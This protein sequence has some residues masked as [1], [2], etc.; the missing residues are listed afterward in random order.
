MRGPPPRKT[1]ACRL[2]VAINLLSSPDDKG[3]RF[4]HG[5]QPWPDPSRPLGVQCNVCASAYSARNGGTAYVPLSHLRRGSPGLDPSLGGY[6]GGPGRAQP[7]MP[8]EARHIEA[9]EG[10]IVMYHAVSPLIF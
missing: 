1:F 9:P 4:S 3:L 7:P 8:D 10:S 2:S 6:G 5:G